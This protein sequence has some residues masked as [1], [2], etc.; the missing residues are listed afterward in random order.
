MWHFKLIFIGW[1]CVFTS[2]ASAEYYYTDISAPSV[3]Q[4]VITPTAIGGHRSDEG[5]MC[6]KND[7]FWCYSSKNFS[8]AIPRNDVRRESWVHHHFQYAVVKK[9]KM[10]VLGI[11]LNIMEILQIREGKKIMRFVYS[12]ERGLISFRAEGPSAR[13]F[14]LENGCG[15]AAPEQCRD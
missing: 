7:A 1:I 9:T 8:F 6:N 12:T 13:S 4:I 3:N 14:V 10:M 5:L 15:L 11:E 2:N